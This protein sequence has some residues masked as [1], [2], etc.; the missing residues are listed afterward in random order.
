MNLTN[1]IAIAGLLC[2]GFTQAAQAVSMTVKSAWNEGAVIELDWGAQPDFSVDE[3]K[4]WPAYGQAWENKSGQVVGS[5]WWVETPW[6]DDAPWQHDFTV[7]FDGLDTSGREYGAVNFVATD[8]TI[9]PLSGNVYGALMSWGA[10]PGASA[11]DRGYALAMMGL[12]M[13]VLALIK[14][15]A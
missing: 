8:A 2:L 11:P 12:G 4:N 14:R 6:P 15:K 9:E 7:I 5:L 13:G 10:D 1:R 3:Y